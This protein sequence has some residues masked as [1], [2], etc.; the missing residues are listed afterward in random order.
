MIQFHSTS[1]L[2]PITAA[3]ARAHATDDDSATT[4]A[5]E[6]EVTARADKVPGVGEIDRAELAQIRNLKNRDREVRQHERA[7]ASAAAGVAHSAPSYTYTRGPDGQLYAIGGE[8]QIDTAPVA[9]DAQA[10]LTKAK[11]IQRAAL[12]PVEPS[13]PDRA[14]AAKA[15]AMAAAARAELQQERTADTAD[16]PQSAADAGSKTG[17][18]RDAEGAANASKAAG[19]VAEFYGHASGALASHAG[20]HRAHAI[21]IHT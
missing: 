8:V 14:V 15:A 10:T 1:F 4:G 2:S 9:G 18:S 7:H 17:G 12:A 13:A 5:A 16:D 20:P 3:P 21:D 6:N 11:Q 19:Q